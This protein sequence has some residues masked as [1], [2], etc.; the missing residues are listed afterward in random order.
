VRAHQLRYARLSNASNS[1]F[2]VAS[3]IAAAVFI[4]VAFTRFHM[5]LARVGVMLIILMRITPRFN[6]IQT[7]LQSL[8]TNIVAYEHVQ[9]MIG[10]FESERESAP[11]AE[12]EI[13][14][15]LTQAIA[16]EGVAMRYGAD[17]PP[18]LEDASFVIPAGRITALIGP[19]G[20]GKSTIADLV[21]GLLEPSQGRLSIDGVTL[22]HRNRRGWREQI[23]YV[24]QEVILLH[25]SIAANLAV[26]MPEADE[27]AMWTALE[28]A[29]ARDFVEKLPDRLDTVVGD[30][31][32]RLSGGE[33]QR[34]ALARGLLRQP[35]LLILDEATSALDWENQMLIARSIERLRGSMTI[36]T[37]AH[38]PSMISF[39]DWVVTVED[40]R[41]VEAGDYSA[42]IERRGSRLRRLIEGEQVLEGSEP[43]SG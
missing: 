6:S 2:Q 33:R 12:T 39:A 1:I 14:P 21:M 35:R 16:F 42:L 8:G 15:P 41:I 4:Y 3:T 19:S 18:V 13:P 9:R 17:T 23:A 20:S 27:A 24:P 7:A 31:G 5:P 11:E 38:R 32:L 34:I 36:I 43:I 25:D 37:I 29:N 28:A 10:S 30:R 40:G 26:A 22:D